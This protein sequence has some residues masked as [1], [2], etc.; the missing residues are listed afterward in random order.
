MSSQY[1]NMES[2]GSSQQQNSSFLVHFPSIVSELIYLSKIPIVLDGIFGDSGQRGTLQGVGCGARQIPAFNEFPLLR[3][4][5]ELSGSHSG[6]GS[7]NTP[8]QP[9]LFSRLE[10]SQMQLGNQNGATERGTG[11]MTA[12]QTMHLVCTMTLSSALEQQIMAG[13][14]DMVLGNWFPNRCVTGL[15]LNQ[16][17][18]ETTFAALVPVPPNELLSFIQPFNVASW[19]LIILSLLSMALLLK[20]IF[21]NQKYHWLDLLGCLIG[22]GMTESTPVPEKLRLFPF[23]SWLWGSFLIYIIYTAVLFDFFMNPEG[24][25]ITSLAGIA[26]SE[27]KVMVNPFSLPLNQAFDKNPDPVLHGIRAKRIPLAPENYFPHIPRTDTILFDEAFLIYL[28]AVGMSR[29]NFTMSNFYVLP[30]DKKIFPPLYRTYFFRKD[31]PDRAK[32][33]MGLEK[34]IQHG[35]AKYDESK[36]IRIVKEM[37]SATSKAGQSRDLH[38]VQLEHIKGVA[39]CLLAAYIGKE[40]ELIRSM[41]PKPKCCPSLNCVNACKVQVQD[42]YG[43]RDISRR[44]ICEEL[45]EASTSYWPML[46]FV[47]A[48]GVMGYSIFTNMVDWVDED[49]TNEEEGGS[50]QQSVPGDPPKMAAYRAFFGK[51]K[52]TAGEAKVEGAKGN[53]SCEPP[54]CFNPCDTK[55]KIRYTMRPFKPED[56]CSTFESWTYGLKMLGFAAAVLALA[57]SVYANMGES[58]ENGDPESGAAAE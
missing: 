36:Y 28:R 30:L 56:K 54:P 5:A 34:Y 55:C 45:Q 26:S 4:L 17:M 33:E 51:A 12:N 37:L 7:T 53:A 24:R 21:K 40:A 43:L 8:V 50:E 35:L 58:E 20:F 1:E 44:D 29:D 16:L 15:C 47:L 57:Y 13:R 18:A 23:T 2:Q 3:R 14:A 27:Y 52:E 19:L 42:K 31:H 48:I 46:V 9:S 41:D 6:L 11:Q 10:Q 39:F 32:A 38:P 49:P 25:R 22:Q